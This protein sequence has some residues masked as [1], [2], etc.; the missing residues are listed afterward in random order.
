MIRNDSMMFPL[1]SEFGLR[2]QF[3]HQ[4]SCVPFKKLLFN[5]SSEDTQ[6]CIF[7]QIVAIPFHDSVW[8][9]ADLFLFAASL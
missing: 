1:L 9:D 4:W 5:D 6:N 2:H 8:F 3:L 7:C